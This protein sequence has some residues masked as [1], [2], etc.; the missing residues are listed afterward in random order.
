MNWSH[1]QRNSLLENEWAI[2]T[3]LSI[4]DVT[5][6]ITLSTPRYFENEILF[7]CV[8]NRWTKWVKLRRMHVVGVDDLC[9]KFPPIYFRNGDFLYIINCAGRNR[10]KQIVEH[11]I[12]INIFKVNIP[13]RKIVAKN[14]L[15]HCLGSFPCHHEVING[16]EDCPLKIIENGQRAI[17]T[18]QVLFAIDFKT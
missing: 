1:S 17:D 10:D 12:D 14:Q 2:G 11:K 5:S 13:E 8:D 9:D 18:I 7:R 16:L 15:R 4:P 6:A 3:S